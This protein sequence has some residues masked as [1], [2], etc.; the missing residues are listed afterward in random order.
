MDQSTEFVSFHPEPRG[1]GIR[2]DLDTKPNQKVPR[3]MLSRKKA[4]RS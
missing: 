4:R 1:L 2:K 3:A